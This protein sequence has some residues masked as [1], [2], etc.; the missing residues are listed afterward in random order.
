MIPKFVW[1][2][3]AICICAIAAVY[4]LFFAQDARQFGREVSQENRLA[5]AV[6]A[7]PLP[8]EP[9]KIE[10]KENKRGCGVLESIELTDKGFI[11][12]IRNRCATRVNVELH[13]KQIAP[14]GTVVNSGWTYAAHDLS[15]NEREEW[16]NSFSYE[17]ISDPR[18]VRDVF[19]TE[20]D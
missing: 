9:L 14:D 18:V 10:I 4:W 11:S 8:V 1:V 5:S 15:Q 6:G 17:F 3:V 16:N 13:W 7:K 2:P 19:W 20:T 12:Y